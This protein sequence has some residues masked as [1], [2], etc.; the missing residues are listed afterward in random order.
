M[1]GEFA[2]EKRKGPN[3]GA[4]CLQ[5]VLIRGEHTGV[6]GNHI[7]VLEGVDLTLK[8]KTMCWSPLHFCSL[9]GTPFLW[10]KFNS[11]K[12]WLFFYSDISALDM[13]ISIPFCC[14]TFRNISLAPAREKEWGSCTP[15]ANEEM[16]SCKRNCTRAYWSYRQMA[17]E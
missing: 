11:L 17:T 10:L 15:V 3:R 6:N 1:C 5:P 14:D 12:E 9:L 4:H 7:Q 2:K 13:L 16:A 8:K